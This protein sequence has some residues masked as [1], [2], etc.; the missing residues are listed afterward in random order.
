MPINESE[1]E[2]EEFE[3]M[4]CESVDEDYEFFDCEHSDMDLVNAREHCVGHYMFRHPMWG[5]CHMC[6][7]HDHPE[8]RWIW[9]G[10]TA[11]LCPRCEAYYWD[12]DVPFEVRQ[13]RIAEGEDRQTVTLLFS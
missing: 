11:P 13:R 10:C 4:D 5:Y 6:V 12:M 9:S 7:T 2:E 3:Y 8:L 1:E